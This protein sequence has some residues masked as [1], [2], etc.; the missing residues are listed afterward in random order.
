MT[1]FSST[2]GLVPEVTNSEVLLDTRKFVAAEG[3]LG[4]VVPEAKGDL[5]VAVTPVGNDGTA[6]IFVNGEKVHAA[7]PYS[8]KSDRVAFVALCKKVVKALSA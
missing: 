5:V 8:S 7:L 4:N 2:R 1:Q 3:K 6:S